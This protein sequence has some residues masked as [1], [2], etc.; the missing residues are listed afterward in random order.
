MY[1]Q[2]KR[3]IAIIVLLC[4]SI[5]FSSC[6]FNNASDFSI[7]FIDVGQGDAALV[8][9]D[10]HFMLI[11]AG[12]KEYEDKVYNTLAD[13]NITHLDIL[14][15]SHM[16]EDHIGGLAKA[17]TYA[18]TIDLAISVSD[19]D[20]S[21]TFK[22]FYKELGIDGCNK[23]T[24]P[25]EGDKYALGSASIEIVATG[26]CSEDENIS[27]VILIKHGK[28]TFLFTG[29]MP[30]NKGGMEEKMCDKYSD[31]FPVTLLKV[32][33]HG[34]NSS[35]TIRFLRMLMPRY[36]IISVGENNRY[37]HPTEQT[38]SRLKQ[39]DVKTYRTDESGSITVISNGS[40]LEF[41]TEY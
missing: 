21:N 16:H 8:S 40:S 28:N 33:H 14:A 1:N 36:A 30:G 20:K 34:S 22:D 13:N 23:I 35:T 31:N 39:A 9:C 11:D 41:R 27:M 32:S 19:Y 5:T 37:G 6:G 4:I 10:G 3:I 2:L 26:D 38:L 15:I 24:V 12:P 29:D 17:L 7:T 25:K 18:T